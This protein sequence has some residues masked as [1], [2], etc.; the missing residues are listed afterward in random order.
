MDLKPCPFCGSRDPLV[1]TYSG[2]PTIFCM[3]CP[4]LMG[5][6][7]STASRDELIA[8]WNHRSPSN[9]LAESAVAP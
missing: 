8:A 9:G 2:A 5:G 6:E 4:A 3:A 1:T 7:E